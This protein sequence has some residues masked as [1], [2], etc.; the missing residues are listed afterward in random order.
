MEASS[1]ESRTEIP[2]LS[3]VNERVEEKWGEVVL[4][5]VTREE[6]NNLGLVDR[7]ISSVVG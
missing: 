3:D 4:K 5:E 1:S 7:V 2:L 6:S